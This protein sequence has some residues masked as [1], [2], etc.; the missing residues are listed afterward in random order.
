[1]IGLENSRDSLNQSDVKIKNQSR[2]GR[3]RFSALVL[4]W[5]L[6]GFQ[7]V[8]LFLISRRDYFGFGFKIEIEKNSIF[9]RRVV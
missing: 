4:F 1:M 7:G 5:V 3:T 6:I 8:F 2:I 9:L